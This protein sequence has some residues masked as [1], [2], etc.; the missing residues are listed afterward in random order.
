MEWM[1]IRIER[2]FTFINI[3]KPTKEA[4]ALL[5]SKKFSEIPKKGISIYYQR[6]QFDAWEMIAKGNS[7]IEVLKDDSVKGRF[8][9][10]SLIK[11]IKQ[12]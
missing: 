4:A 2:L 5:V 3:M 8:D 9:K 11:L 10:R 7:I 6:E 1:P 12:L